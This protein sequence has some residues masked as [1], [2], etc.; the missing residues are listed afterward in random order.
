MQ[1]T[2]TMYVF[3]NITKIAKANHVKKVMYVCLLQ[4]TVDDLHIHITDPRQAYRLDP[5]KFIVLCSVLLAE[6]H[7][8]N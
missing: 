6:C 2:S 3:R 1:T 7:D 5:L 4:T 8:S